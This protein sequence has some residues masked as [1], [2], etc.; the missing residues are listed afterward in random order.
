MRGGAVVT[1]FV[2]SAVASLALAGVF[3]AGGD[4][5]WEGVLLFVAL[6]GLGVGLIVW[7]KG[8]FGDNEVVEARPR[9]GSTREERVA[10]EESLELGAER[11]GRRRAILLALGGA[12]GAF[13]V[14][15]AFPV[16]SLGPG[17]GDALRRTPWRRGLR[18]VSVET[19]RPVRLGELPTGSILTVFPEGR[20]DAE[21][22]AAVL[23]H[24]STGRLDLPDDRGRFA[25]QGHVA[26]SKICTH[27]GCPVGL[28]LENEHALLCPCHLSTFDVLDGARPIL[29]PA[30]RPLPQLPIAVDAEGFFVALG[31]FTAP[32]GPA[33]WDVD[34]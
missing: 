6:G 20:L 26:Y 28:Y 22:A 17:P 7:A 1:A 29:G 5:Q 32:V 19:G 13:A 10:F 25:P 27:V 15:L 9:F 24:V 2:V 3:V 31:D 16:R 21:D 30:T 12:L 4:A 23:I 11:V 14:A 8:L 18:L 33:Y 34:R